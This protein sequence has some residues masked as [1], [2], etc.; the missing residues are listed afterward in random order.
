MEKNEPQ[1]N[2]SHVGSGRPVRVAADVAVEQTAAAHGWSRIEHRLH[3]NVFGR[4][5]ARLVVG[6]SKTGRAVEV[7]LWFPLGFGTGFIDDPTPSFSAGG[8]D[9]GKLDTVLGWLTGPSTYPPLPATLVLIPCS[10]AK[11]A[12][13]AA[14]RDLYIGDHFKLALRAAE[15]RAAAVDARVAILSAKHGLV[16]LDRVLAPYD[17]RFGDPDAIAADLLATHLSVQHVSTIEALLPGR[18]RAAVQEALEII[19]RRGGA[20]I[21]LANLYA[22]AAGIGYQRAVLS[23][24]L[25]SNGHDAARPTAEAS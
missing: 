22:G 7:A 19:E 13:G 3:R 2:P 5:Q 16:T 10:A 21:E 6:F 20:R 4:G 11:L 15:A 8:R 25:A 12:V 23:R 9:G 24:L 1:G 17:C 14:A 18:Y